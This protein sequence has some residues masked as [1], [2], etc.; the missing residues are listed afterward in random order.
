MSTARILIADDFHP[1]LMKGLQDHGYPFDYK[2][3]IQKKA[4][5][6]TIHQ[7]TGFIFRSKL[8]CDDTFFRQSNQLQW[9][10]RGG[11]GMDNID[12]E[13][14]FQRHIHLINAPEGNRN[15]V[16]EHALGM[17]FSLSNH[18]HT[19]HLEIQHQQWLREAN[20]GREIMGLTLGII[21]FGNN[22]SAMAQKAEGVGMKVLAYDKYLTTNNLPHLN[23]EKQLYRIFDEA[24][25]V[26]LH[27]PLTPETYQMVNQS[28][29][30]QFSKPIGL[31]NTSRGP[32]VNTYDIEEQLIKGKLWAFGADVLE[33]EK[34][35]TWEPDDPYLRLAQ[36]P[37]VLFTP[38][39]AGWTK[40]SY[41]RISTILLEKIISLKL[42][43]D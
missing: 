33:N 37:S 17:I 41:H 14:A 25:W 11:S 18:L 23:S 31:I 26:S 39:V 36:I 16:A 38:H 3:Y 12:V 27:I 13:Q 21:G 1:D 2:P 9:I 5:L 6:D 4:I 32:I 8:H 20:R 34:P 24:D 15:A 29:L 19:A 7:Y 10:A 35:S 42:P 40:E 30:Q 28:Y 22:G 43:A